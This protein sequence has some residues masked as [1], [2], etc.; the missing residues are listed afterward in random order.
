MPH[1]VVSTG[2]KVLVASWEY[3][4][5]TQKDTVIYTDHLV[6]KFSVQTWGSKLKPQHLRESRAWQHTATIPVLGEQREEGPWEVLASQ[7]SHR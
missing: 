4:L 2:V 6:V 7:S 5:R 1:P 3:E